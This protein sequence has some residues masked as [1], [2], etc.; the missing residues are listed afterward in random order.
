VI[1]LAKISAVLL[2]ATAAAGSFGGSLVHAGELIAREP[3]NEKPT[4][5]PAS[6][7]GKKVVT[8]YG[9]P[10]RVGNQVGA[11][12]RTFRVYTVQEVDGDRMRLVSESVN[13]WI[14][15]T[16]VVLLDQAIDFYSQ[17][18]RSKPNNAAAF[19]QRGLV[20]KF[21]EE[22]DKALADFT[23]AIRLDPKD[24][25]R[26]ADRGAIFLERKEYD[27]AIA[28]DT[29]AIRIDPQFV[30][31]FSNRGLAWSNKK[32][33]DKAIADYTEAIRID[34]KSAWAYS[35]RG[36]AW[37][38]KQAY[39]KAIADY[40]EAIRIDPK[41]AW[42]YGSRGFAW[43]NK[44]AY[45]N[46][47]ADYTE[48]IRINPND[49]NAYAN[50][51]YTWA[52]KKEYDK[53]IADDTEAIRINPK[54]RNAYGNRGAARLNKREYDK[55]I[56]DFTK[57]IRIEPELPGAYG[58]RALIWATCPDEKLRDGK[59]AVESAT[60]AC[61]LTKW[62]NARYLDA[63][64]AA[65]AEASDFESAVKWQTKANALYA[66]PGDKSRGEARLKLY[67]E[68][69]PYRDAGA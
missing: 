21:K 15:S 66:D 50:R 47:I 39:D 53:A 59:K 22:T 49:F 6:L 65:C 14:A 4:Q 45:D 12:D 30:S 68:K 19:R 27:K 57:A 67:Q 28:D 48:A 61:E 24:A 26:Y 52:R 9:A 18:I 17:E 63:L 33:Y 40:T 34:P 32:E 62:N 23:E 1:K 29:E 55:A 31:A 41:S 64:G 60:K 11:P 37:S 69:K 44:E 8:K 7:I 16:E 36:F 3:R 38:N 54:D 42:A 10:V 13:G 51:G 25:L 5:A 58:G 35:S 56:A 2:V 20:W 43:T 46:A